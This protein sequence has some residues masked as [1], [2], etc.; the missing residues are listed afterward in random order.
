[1][2]LVIGVAL[3]LKRRAAGLEA[4]QIEPPQINVGPPTQTPTPENRATNAFPTPVPLPSEQLPRQVPSTSLTVK[5]REPVNR[6]ENAVATAV[7]NDGVTTV[8]IDKAGNITGLD[9]LPQTIRQQIGEAWVAEK[10]KARG[11]ETELAGAPINLRGSGNDQTFKLLSPARV[12][13]ISD[14]PSFEWEKL[15]G[16]TSYRVL[17]GDLKGHEI[18]KSEELTADCITWTLPSPLTRGEIYAW[19]VEATVN[20][21]KIFSPGTSASQMKF[22]VLSA[23]SAK[24]LEQLKRTRSHLAL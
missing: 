7:L 20:G 3:L 21:K 16:A 1:M 23:R 17:L 19:E 4:K 18:A 6:V 11:I 14:R 9:E 24:E 13:I 5:N 2:A 12:V 22:R 15:A 10:I 8:T